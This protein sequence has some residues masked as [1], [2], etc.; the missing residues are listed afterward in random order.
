M[1]VVEHVVINCSKTHFVLSS[2][3]DVYLIWYLYDFML[4]NDEDY[5]VCYMPATLYV[6]EVGVPTLRTADILYHI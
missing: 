2:D 4:E 6:Y 5:Y 1:C 3:A